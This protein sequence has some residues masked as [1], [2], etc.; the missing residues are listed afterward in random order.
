M[1]L[2][3]FDIVNVRFH[4]TELCDLHYGETKFS[5]VWHVCAAESCTSPDIT[6][7]VITALGSTISCS[8]IVTLGDSQIITGCYY[9]LISWCC[10]SCTAVYRQN[11]PGKKTLTHW[12][13]A[14]FHYL[15]TVVRFIL[16]HPNLLC[17]MVAG[18]LVRS[19]P[20]RCNTK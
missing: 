19:P 7:N 17:N 15:P 14:H 3:S 4:L 18:H 12:R 9:D 1:F 5:G 8:Q 13:Y 20:F 6:G 2:A 16:S 10:K 11:P